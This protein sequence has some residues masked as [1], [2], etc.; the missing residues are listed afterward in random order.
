MSFPSLRG[1]FRASFL[2]LSVFALTL[3]AEPL[4]K[5]TEIDFFATSQAAISRAWQLVPMV[6]WLPVRY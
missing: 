5:R 6:D 3:E 4:S 1:V 2:L